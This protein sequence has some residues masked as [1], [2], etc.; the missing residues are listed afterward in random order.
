LPARLAASWLPRIAEV[1]H[2]HAAHRVGD[3]RDASIAG[4]EGDAI[5]EVAR[6]HADRVLARRIRVAPAIEARRVE[7]LAELRHRALAAGE[8]V[9]ED[10]EGSHSPCSASRSA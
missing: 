3:R 1:A 2:D 8:A 4:G 10:D 9:Q 6:E 7:A 5:R